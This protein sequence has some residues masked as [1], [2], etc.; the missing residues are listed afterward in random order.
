MDPMA[1]SS[2]HP[3]F[4]YMTKVLLVPTNKIL[5]LFKKKKEKKKPLHTPSLVQAGFKVFELA[6][7]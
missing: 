2:L 3:P 6:L 1:S 7:S 5:L 4:L